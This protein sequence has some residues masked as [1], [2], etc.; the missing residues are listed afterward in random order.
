MPYADGLAAPLE[1]ERM[2]EQHVTTS[3]WL[4]ADDR[5]IHVSRSWDPFA[6]ENGG[7]QALAAQVVGRS[8]HEFVADDPTRMWIQAVLSLARTRGTAVERPYRCDSP[9]ERRF[10]SM[11]VIPEQGGK[12]RVDHVLLATEPRIRPVTI[13][14]AAAAVPD[15]A[16]RCSICG[17]VKTDGEWREADEPGGPVDGTPEIIVAYTVCKACQF[18]P[19]R[20]SGPI[21]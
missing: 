9:T 20:F 19:P 14:P 6:R 7:D 15:L 16:M 10:M 2:A 21:R 17:R 3:Y 12:L 13:R 11:T 5:I 18:L 4:D 1:T 8:I